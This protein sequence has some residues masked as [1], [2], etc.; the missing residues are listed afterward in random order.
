MRHICV[1]WQRRETFIISL[2]HSTVSD[3]I[4]TVCSSVC[5]SVEVKITMFAT[6][7][8]ILQL[9]VSLLRYCN[10]LFVCL[11]VCRSKNAR[12]VCVCVCACDDIATVCSPRA[13]RYCNCL[14]VCCDIATVC[15][16]VCVSVEVK[17][18]A[19]CVCVCVCDDIATVCSSVCLSVKV[20]ITM[21]A[22]AHRALCVCVCVCVW[23]YC[24][25]LFVCLSVEVKIMMFVAILQLSVRLSECPLS[26][27]VF[28]VCVCVRNK[29]HVWLTFYSFIFPTNKCRACTI[30]KKCHN[31]WNES[32]NS[33]LPIRS[34]MHFSLFKGI[35]PTST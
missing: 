34:D 6:H 28:E 23:R 18:R 25:G 11:S 5:L 33:R 24:N 32:T 35:T 2:I 7:A 20:K 3:D 4:A 8:P 27:W 10:C 9:S 15:S 22:R 1:I 12:C 16:S 17:T 31:P 21:F 30:S 19:V 29:T 14:S 13:R 26:V